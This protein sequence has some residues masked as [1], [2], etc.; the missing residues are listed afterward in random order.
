MEYTLR[1][2]YQGAIQSQ[3]YTIA[4][5]VWCNTIRNPSS[6]DHFEF[7]SRI[8]IQRFY[9]DDALTIHQPPILINF[10]IYT[11]RIFGSLKMLQEMLICL[12]WVFF[13]FMLCFRCD[14]L[15][16]KNNHWN[17]LLQLHIFESFVIDWLLLIISNVLYLLYNYWSLL[18]NLKL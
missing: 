8:A 18:C 17:K 2:L 14:F 10:S 6:L 12:C 9:S 5:Y 15:C 3:T 11:F 7:R 13:E 4:L 1:V 16:Y